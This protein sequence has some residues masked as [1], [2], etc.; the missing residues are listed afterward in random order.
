[1]YYGIPILKGL[2]VIIP[3]YLLRLENQNANGYLTFEIL[4]VNIYYISNLPDNG[5]W[6]QNCQAAEHQLSA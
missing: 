2:L 6:K 1:M 3:T 5:V 4:F